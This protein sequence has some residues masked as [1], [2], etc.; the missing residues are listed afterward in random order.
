MPPEAHASS[1]GRRYYYHLVNPNICRA[2]WSIRAGTP[3]TQ[4]RWASCLGRHAR[5]DRTTHWV[6]EKP[7]PSPRLDTRA[8]KG[9]EPHHAFG[10][11]QRTRSVSYPHAPEF[12]GIG[13]RFIR[14]EGHVTVK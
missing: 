8:Y 1:A 11:S 6:G 4:L 5:R 12:V 9:Q 13:R 7:R 2:S 14:I 10:C 3:R